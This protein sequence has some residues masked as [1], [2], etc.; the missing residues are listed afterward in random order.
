M[1]SPPISWMTNQGPWLLT[2]DFNSII[3]PSE[4]QGGAKFNPARVKEFN[5]FI[6]DY[7]LL[8]IGFVNPKFTWAT[9]A[10]LL[11]ETLGSQHVQPTVDGKL[12]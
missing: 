10:S 3:K 5:D 6:M 8:D 1:E 11:K 4:K 9:M 12:S 2:E 7:G